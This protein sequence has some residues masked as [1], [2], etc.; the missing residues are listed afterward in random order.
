MGILDRFWKSRS[1]NMAVL[2]VAA[3]FPLI[4]AVG[5]GID[6][7]RHTSAHQHLQDLADATSLALAATEDMSETKMRELAVDVIA[8]NR[9]LTRIGPVTIASLKIDDDKVDVLLNGAIQASFMSLA[10]YDRLPTSASA[11][12][13][14][15][16]K[17]QVE[18]ALVLDN[19]YSMSAEN[20]FGVSRIETLREAASNLV[21]ELLKEDDGAVRIA[22]VPYAEYVNVGT[23]HRNA[24]WLDVPADY[25]T[26][27]KPAD[28]CE[29]RT[30]RKKCVA[31][32]DKYA[33][34]RIVDGIA[35]QGQC[36]GGCTDSETINVEPYQYCT[37]G[38][39][40]KTYKWYGCVG[41]RNVD[42]TRLHDQS[43]SVRY[44]GYV[45]RSQRCMSPIMP[46]TTN[47]S[48]LKNAIEDM[49]VEVNGY[50]P[51]TYIPAGL[52][53]GLN[54][55]SPTAPFTE[56]AAYHPA[57]EK[58]RKVVVLMTDGENTLRYRERDGKH[59]ELPGKAGQKKYEQAVDATNADTM[60]ICDNMKAQNIEI[61]S[62]AF[63]VDDADAQDMLEYCAASSEHYYDAS[64]NEQLLAAFADISA[65][66][67]VVRLAR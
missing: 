53:W 29:T 41:S 63:M 8:A 13:E 26:E 44:P 2:S 14:R 62:V 30:T 60:A 49:V 54:V 11:L 27:A 10:G 20:A 36:G 34:Q 66:L 39:S 38:R 58:P 55:L 21:S 37:G 47:A 25:S 17:G 16:V 23:Q 24:P 31:W 61:Y 7:A 6:Y 65:S 5:L 51:L 22:L 1:G 50:R 45:E 18:V 42:D 35:V 57:N 59:E 48:S 3:S 28:K 15:A 40:A 67:R 64:D 33:C 32:A 12:A 43:S 56:G 9:D 46:L 19:T 4:F 52:I